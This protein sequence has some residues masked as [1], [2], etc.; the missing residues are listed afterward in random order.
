MQQHTYIA[1]DTCVYISRER[2]TIVS[3]M[4]VWQSLGASFRILVPH[5]RCQLP[6]LLSCQAQAIILLACM[7]ASQCLTLRHVHSWAAHAESH[8]HH[9]ALRAAPFTVFAAGDQVVAAELSL[10]SKEGHQAGGAV[11]GQQVLQA[12][13][14]CP[15]GRAQGCECPSAADACYLLHPCMPPFCHTMHRMPLARLTGSASCFL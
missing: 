4:L 15:I 8:M 1:F 9:T 3:C 7:H 6:L 12:V 14:A 13:L 2:S 10:L 5:V 11:M